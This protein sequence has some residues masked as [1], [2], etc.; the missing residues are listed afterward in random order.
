[1]KSKE[2]AIIILAVIVAVSFILYSYADSFAT[3]SRTGDSITVSIAYLLLTPAYVLMLVLLAKTK[4]ARGFIAGLLIIVSFDILSYP[5]YITQS[6]V[7][8]SEASSYVGLDTILYRTFPNYPLGTLGLYILTPAFLLI[9]AYE[10]VFPS[11]FVSLVKRGA[12]A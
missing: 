3:W 2:T 8:P 7:L 6:G 9:I 4:G 12:G 1:M 10:I 11:T 5:H